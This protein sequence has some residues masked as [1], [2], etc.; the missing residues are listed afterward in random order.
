MSAG[1]RLPGTPDP[2]H[3]WPGAK[4]LII[5]GDAWGDPAGQL[6]ML[7][8]GGGQTRHAW[9][10]AGETL[11]LSGYYAVAYDARGLEDADWA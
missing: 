2:M 5:A 6:V 4:G 1:K 10:G 8:H 11:G 7:L 3:R 9:K